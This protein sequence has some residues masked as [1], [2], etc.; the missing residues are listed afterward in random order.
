MGLWGKD[1]IFMD[2]VDLY[3]FKKDIKNAPVRLQMIPEAG[4]LA[5]ID[6]P[7][8]VA[9]AILDF[10]TEYLDVASLAQPYDGFPEVLGA[11]HVTK[12]FKGLWSGR[13]G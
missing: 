2:P 1:D 5:M 13:L 12:D 9:D 11:Q 4:H 10:I 6:Q 7:H 8:V 3:R